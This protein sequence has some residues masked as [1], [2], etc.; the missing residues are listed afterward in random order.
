MSLHQL[1]L[2]SI[3]PVLGRCCPKLRILYLQNN[4]IPAIHNVYRLKALNYLNLA[5]NN[6]KVIEGLRS[7]EKLQKLDLTVNFID[8]DA[9][10]DS[11]RELT[12]NI[13]LKEL[14]LVGNPC[15]SFKYYRLYVI[16]QLPKLEKLD[17]TDILRSERMDVLKLH[18]EIESAL[19]EEV[20]K[21]RQELANK[22]EGKVEERKPLPRSEFESDD[23]YQEYL[24]QFQLQQSSKVSAYTPESRVEMYKE[25]EE[26]ERRKEEERRAVQSEKEKDDP[27]KDALKK[28]NE[29]VVV[30]D[31]DELPKQRNMGRYDF[32]I[33][34]DTATNSIIVDISLPRYLDT[35]LLDIDVHPL[36]FQLLVKG[37]LLLLHFDEEIRVDQ[38]KVQRIQ[39]N[40]HL[41]LTCPKLNA[42]S[43][44]ATDTATKGTST[45]TST[46]SSTLKPASTTSLN[47]VLNPSH[48][49]STAHRTSKT[50]DSSSSAGKESTMLTEVS[51]VRSEKLEKERQERETATAQRQKSSTAQE[52]EEMLR[53]LGLDASGVP[54]L[55]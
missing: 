37:K 34:N 29:K 19:R 17:G 48:A 46:S 9:L 50:S 28:L 18:D 10:A 54:D 35:S 16:S 31:G 6:I 2:E 51:A 55:E 11:M 53:K 4:I 12:H 27:W 36:W 22:Q 3:S 39:A 42:N 8:V 14:Y 40:G 26:V 44:P 20:D 47:Q 52:E 13:H 21:K 1:K 38:C 33:K 5:L 45:L 15:A 32:T 43:T 49:L 24:D 23:E 30:K 7:C 41:L 25:Q